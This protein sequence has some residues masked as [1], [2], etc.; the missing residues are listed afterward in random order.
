MHVQIRSQRT[1]KREKG[2]F[3]WP[4]IWVIAALL[5]AAWLASGVRPA[6]TWNG[7]MDV[8]RVKNRERYTQFAV[9]GVAICTVLGIARVLRAAKK[10]RTRSTPPSSSCVAEDDCAD[11]GRH[12]SVITRSAGRQ[13]RS[14]SVRQ[15]R[16]EGP[17][18]LDS[19]H[20]RTGQGDE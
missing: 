12:S 14:P 4:I 7:V 3:R 17:Y 20:R 6:I 10:N 2:E 19:G 9:L 1:S 16:G 11:I 15:A 5:L 8:L 18:D 13:H